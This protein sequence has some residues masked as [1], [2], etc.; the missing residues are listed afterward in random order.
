MAKTIAITKDSRISP[1]KP[2]RFPTLAATPP[3]TVSP[4]LVLL[5]GKKAKNPET[6]LMYEFNAALEYVRP[7]P[8]AYAGSKGERAVHGRVV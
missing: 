5:L 6:A 8:G 4:I 2:D 7:C 1:K 3:T